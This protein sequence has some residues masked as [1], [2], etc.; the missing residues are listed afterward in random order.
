MKSCLFQALRRHGERV[1]FHYIDQDK[2]ITYTDLELEARQLVTFLKKQGIKKRDYVL[3]AFES[4]KDL[5]V[6]LLA[7]AS[8][9]AIMLPVAP[10]LTSFELTNIAKLVSFKAV[11][12]DYSFLARH[13]DVFLAQKNVQALLTLKSGDQELSHEL[14]FLHST[15][16]PS[17]KPEK[18]TAPALDQVITCHMTFKGFA[19]P[20]G[21]EHTYSDYLEAIESCARI[22]EFKPGHRLLLTL[23]SYPVFGLVTNLLFP[24]FEGSELFVSDKKLSSLLQLIER[25]QIKHLNVV[26]VILEK[27]LLEATKLKDKCDLSHLT[28]VAGGSYLTEQLFAQVFERFNLKVTQGYGLTETL[29]ILTNHPRDTLPGTLGVLMRSG[30]E[31]KILD[32]KGFEVPRGK[33]GEICLRGQG[34]IT[35]YIGDGPFRDQLFRAGWLRTGDLAYFDEQNHIVF[36]GRRLNFT[37]VLGNMVDLKE[38]E[39]LCKSIFGVKMARAFVSVDRDREKLALSLFVTKDFLLTKKDITDK[40]RQNLSSYKIP[41]LIKIYKNSYAEVT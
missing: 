18:L 12:C 24:L 27:M 36:L 25:Y 33:A 23:P 17:K 34:V 19:T 22:F 9:G 31:L 41:S 37:K 20:L 4:E 39:D 40:L 30:V 8:L 32:S 5:F 6:S 38:V 15:L 35:E 11:L 10:H 3:V 28:I 7:L 13:Q 2:E 29:P 1:A 21:V 26:P 14:F 16:S